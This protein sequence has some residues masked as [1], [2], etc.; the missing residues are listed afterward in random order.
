MASGLW[1]VQEKDGAQ[2]P[3]CETTFLGKVDPCSGCGGP[4]VPTKWYW[5]LR[6]ERIAF[7]STVVIASYPIASLAVTETRQ[8]WNLA[9]SI[10]VMIPMIYLSVG[11]FTGGLIGGMTE[12]FLKEAEIP[13]RARLHFSW[14]RYL[15]E[16]GL[17]LVVML[18]FAALFVVLKWLPS[19]L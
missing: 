12:R 9:F 3:K 5:R 10:A 2:C 8:R 4:T 1:G 18:A 6:V 19:K 11:F 17:M 16:F 7:L 15:A 14:V 13:P